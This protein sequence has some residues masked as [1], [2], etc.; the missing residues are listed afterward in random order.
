MT[1]DL[2]RSS[3]AAIGQCKQLFDVELIAEL[4]LLLTDRDNLALVHLFFHGYIHL[5]ALFRF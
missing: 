4:C 3:P 5:Y 2:S 1:S